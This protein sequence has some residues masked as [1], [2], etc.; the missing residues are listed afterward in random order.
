MK[1]FVLAAI[2]AAL[3]APSFAAD[4]P[5]PPSAQAPSVDPAAATAAEPAKEKLICTRESETGSNRIKKVC[6]PAS[7][8]GDTDRRERDALELSRQLQNAR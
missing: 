8:A 6:R 3:A 5:A 2:L 4:A 7:Q 1:P